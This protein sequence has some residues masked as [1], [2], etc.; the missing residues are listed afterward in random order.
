[1]P[2]LLRA[3]LEF[4]E[5]RESSRLLLNKLQRTECVNKVMISL[6]HNSHAYILGSSNRLAEF[7]VL[8]AILAT[9]TQH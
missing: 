7:L 5:R 4:G 1:M 8:S 2:E 9:H 6:V 3:A